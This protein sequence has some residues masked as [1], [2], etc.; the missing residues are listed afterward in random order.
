MSRQGRE[1]SIAPGLVPLPVCRRGRRRI[2]AA[3][4]N[5]NVIMKICGT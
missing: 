4:T 3:S 5:S 1:S 2:I